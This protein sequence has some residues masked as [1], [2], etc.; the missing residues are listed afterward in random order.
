MKEFEPIVIKILGDGKERDGLG[1][2]REIE[3]YREFHCYGRR[4]IEE[5]CGNCKLRFVC[6]STRDTEIEIPVADLHKRSIRNVTARTIADV[7]TNLEYK[8]KKVE[9]ADIRRNW[10][11]SRVQIDFKKVEVRK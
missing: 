10:G 6:L 2:G 7:F 4:N 8:F 1:G 3:R 9:S 11:V 5:V